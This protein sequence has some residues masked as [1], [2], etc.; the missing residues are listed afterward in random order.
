MWLIFID[1]FI[2][3]TPV[4]IG[5]FPA[6]SNS[7]CNNSTNKIMNVWI[8]GHLSACPHKTHVQSNPG[9]SNPL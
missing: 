7:Y 5:C 6:V 9:N 1:F 3:M 8:A 4:F 2:I